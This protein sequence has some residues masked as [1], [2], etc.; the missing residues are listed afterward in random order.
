MNDVIN[1][2]AAVEVL[3]WHRPA[4]QMPPHMEGIMLDFINAAGDR[5]I[6]M[7]CAYDSYGEQW[8]GIGADGV[9]NPI[10]G[11]VLAWTFDVQGPDD[12]A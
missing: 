10:E 7:G 2:P 5:M 3:V 11:R 4:D 9:C 6:G 8:V 1:K 12:E